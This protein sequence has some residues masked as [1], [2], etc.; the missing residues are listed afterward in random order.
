M[1][2]EDEALVS[3]LVRG[4]PLAVDVESRPHDAH[5]VADTVAAYV[6]GT[7][8]NDQREEFE[9]RLATDEDLRHVWHAVR[10]ERGALHSTGVNEEQPQPETGRKFFLPMLAMAAAALL[11]FGL[12]QIQGDSGGATKESMR[13][14][15]V[16]RAAELR[17]DAVWLGA[18]PHLADEP[19]TTPGNGVYR[20]GL[21]LRAPKGRYLASS[22]P[23][24]HFDV[25]DH[26]DETSIR[27]ED[28]ASAKLIFKGTSISSPWA[29]PDDAPSLTPGHRYLW[30][31]ETRTGGAVQEA[32]AAFE[33]ASIEEQARLAA[34]LSKLDS[35]GDD[36]DRLLGA[37]IVLDLGF[38][39]EAQRRIEKLPKAMAQTPTGRRLLKSLAALRS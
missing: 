3:A 2:R 27:I 23:T 25:P 37:V 20:D 9:R 24:F 30:H 7:L 26:A 8:S 12:W 19:P 28:E 6:A 17:K 18:L 31:L 13:T 29:W 38:I 21:V 5:A 39:D 11:A 1:N 32:S 35:S 33:V 14:Q 4:V 36:A 15:L 22:G 34:L 10:A 16:A